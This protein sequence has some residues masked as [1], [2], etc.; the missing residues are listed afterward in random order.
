MSFNRTSLLFA[1]TV[2]F[3]LPA[4]PSFAQVFT[5]VAASAGVA[6]LHDGATL[7]TDMGMG[8]GGAWFDYD[9]DG[10]LDLY[11][12]MRT[13]A[14]KLF[15]NNGTGTFTDVAA[16][17]GVADA[18][19]DGSG[20]VAFDYNNDGCKDLYLA[21][22]NA[23]VLFKND[24]DGTFTDITAGSG[25]AASGTR[26]GTSA[27]VGDY[28]EDG[29]LD[30]YVAHHTPVD[31]YGVPDDK[32][33]DQD[34]LFHNN[35]DGTW[36]DVSNMLLGST[37]RENAS[38]IG[39]WTDFDQDGDLDIY[40]IRDCGFDGAGPMSLWRNDG[41]TNGVSNWTFTEVSAAT[42]SNFC[43]NGMGVAVGDYNRNGTMD[44]FFTDNGSAGGSGFP[45]RAGTVLLKNTAGSFSDA[46]VE[47]GVSSLAFSWGANFLDYDLDG[48]QDLFMAGGSLNPGTDVS[49]ELWRNNATGTSFSN[50]TASSGV[51]DLTRSRAGYYGDYDAD[52][53]PDLFLFNY[54][55]TSRLFRNNNANGNNHFIVDLQGVASN[56]DGTGARIALTAGGVTQHY[57]T[58]SGSSLGGGDDTAAYFGLGTAS[59]VTSMTITWPSGTVQTLTNLAANQ[60]MTV[61]ESSDPP[62]ST[63]F[64]DVAAAAGVSLTHSEL[65]GDMGMGTGAA[66]F[67]YDNDGDQD[68]YMT[69]RLGSA[70]RLFRNNGNG[71]FTDVAAAAGVAD[72]GRDGSGVAVAD[73]NNDGCKDL[74]LANGDDDVLFR[75]NCDGTF[76]NATA[77]SGLGASEER[78]GTSASWGDYNKDG[79]VDLYVAHH[80]PIEGNTFTGDGEQDYLFHNDGDG[81]FTDVSAMLL[82]ANRIG[83]SF[84]AGWTDYD[85]DGDLDLYTIRDCPFGINSGP[86]RL[87][88]NDGGTNGVSAWTFT[89]TS[90]T[91]NADWCQ[92]GM[93]LAVGDYNRD[94][95]MDF[96]YTDN[97][98]ATLEYPKSRDGTILLK[99]TGGAFVDA[100]D[101]AGVSSPTSRGAPTFSTMTSTAGTTSSWPAAPSMSP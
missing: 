90:A 10:D 59:T 27:S 20:V 11:M 18:G 101:E 44:L 64:T 35:G 69:M 17:A 55:A 53:D 37:T 3:S 26:R 34:Y 8:A 86:M 52:G 71:A 21:N 22:S 77:G 74:Y 96:F 48:W 36:T 79:F 42:G 75:N 6:V 7:N 56:R 19:H 24:C 65:T 97:G 2:L 80:M 87:Y 1:S 89:E 29:F 95:W 39:A 100:T 83:R 92:N 66:W 72:S 40:L 50:V 88:R 9:N 70:N 63:L 91:A 14:N 33:K 41:G 67:D 47:A 43:Q 4:A 16:S 61:V 60:R 81:T 82:G 23:D 45:E 57:E 62:A 15:S 58:R 78:R 73:F 51:I 28:D 94:G 32:T 99:N 38:F 25:L 31:G 49:T 85:R 30:L 13:G 93:G 5:D 46:T 12:T 98:S 54:G 84:I 76:T 68:L